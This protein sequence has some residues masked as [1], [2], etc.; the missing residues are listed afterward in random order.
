[1]QHGLSAPKLRSSILI[2]SAWIQGE[3]AYQLAVRSQLDGKSSYL[4]ARNGFVKQPNPRLFF[5][6]STLGLKV[7]WYAFQHGTEHRH[8]RL[9]PFSW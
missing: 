1:M 8:N 9:N 5:L 4:H 6:H 7:I 3:A 2:D